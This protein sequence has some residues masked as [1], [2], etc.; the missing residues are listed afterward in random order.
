MN[1]SS[2]RHLLLPLAL[3]GV[4]TG[5]AEEKKEITV[6]TTA[7]EK[8]ERHVKVVINHDDQ[9]GPRETV[10][11]LGVETAPADPTLATQL[12]LAE[13]TGLVVH[14]VLEGTPAAALLKE[15]DVLTKFNDQV[16]ID[17]HQLSVLVRSRKA[18]D[19]V[20][21][22]VFRSGKETAVKVKLGTHEVPKMAGGGGFGPGE[23]FRIFHGGM[24]GMEGLQNLPG[25]ARED[26]DHV[27]RMLGDEHQNLLGRHEVRIVSRNHEG[28]STILNLN[29]GDIVYSDDEGSLEV[30]ASDG[31]REL[32]VKN[33]KGEVTFQGSIA[34]E[35][36]RKKLPPAVRARVG[37]I[38][39]INIGGETDGKFEQ[40][41]AAVGQPHKT[42]LERKVI[43][44]EAPPDR[45]F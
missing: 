27:L 40:E 44:G 28:G 38:E 25:M 41:G 45:S 32:T 17:Q 1:L 23:Q 22:T 10:T 35:E 4:L 26:V 20:S 34:S 9:A 14:R 2:L 5:H 33:P 21:L 3:A 13:G 19:E 15:H 31:K 6:T 37:K 24:P 43:H 30:K 36:D 18:G 29:Q 8:H 7:P 11:F 12:G 42:R 39:M 16:L